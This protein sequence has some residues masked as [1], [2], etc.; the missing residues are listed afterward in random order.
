MSVATALLVAAA[1][2]QE[3]EPVTD[4]GIL[5]IFDQ[6]DS[7]EIAVARVGAE[8]GQAESTRQLGAAIARAQQATQTE[9]RELGRRLKIFNA[10]RAN[11][12]GAYG[13]TLAKLQAVPEAE[14][15]TAYLK[16]QMVIERN[17][18]AALAQ[19]SPLARNPEL[20]GFLG[21]LRRQFEHQLAATSALIKDDRPAGGEMG[22]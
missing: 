11:E 2:A 20:A 9:G 3:N 13:Q 14:F 12:L 8:R 6:L 21:Q 5:A 7:L 4:P 16:Q 15:D 22:R 19:M 10:P 1:G 18:V 17:V